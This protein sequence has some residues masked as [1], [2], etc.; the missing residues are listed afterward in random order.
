[1]K[2]MWNMS[3]FVSVWV[4]GCFMITYICE[5]QWENALCW[6]VSLLMLIACRWYEWKAEEI[7]KFNQF[8][9]A[10]K[11][12]EIVSGGITKIMADALMNAGKTDKTD[13]NGREQE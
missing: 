3:S 1:M 4:M 11:S 2:L 7:E 5:K 12:S 8:L 9:L 6:G 10:K 13:G